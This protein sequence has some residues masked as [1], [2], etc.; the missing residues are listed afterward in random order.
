MEDELT[1]I[2]IK[3]FILDPGLGFGKTYEHNLAILKNLSKLKRAGI[4]LM[5]GHSNKAFIGKA[6]GKDTNSRLFGTVAVS[7]LAVL[8][9]ANLLRVHDVAPSKDA[10]IM[11]HAVLTEGIE[12]K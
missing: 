8:N 2:G 10:A 9:G 11:A 7:A 12:K 3:K 5:I 4:P 6:T 1:E